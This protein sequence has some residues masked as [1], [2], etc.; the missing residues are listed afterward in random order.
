MK[1]NELLKGSFLLFCCSLVSANAALAQ[2]AKPAAIDVVEKEEAIVAQQD[3]VSSDTDDDLRKLDTVV[4]TGSRRRGSARGDFAPTFE[5]SED[6]IT[7]FAAGDLGE[8]VESLTPLLGGASGSSQE[9]PL[10]LLNGKRISGFREIRS[11]PPEAL[12]RVDVLPPE[13][14]LEYGVQTNQS[15]INFVLKTSFQKSTGEL[16]S[17]APTDGGQLQ[18]EGTFNWLRTDGDVRLSVDASYTKQTDLLESD[19]DIEAS[20]TLLGDSVGNVTGIPNGAEID[21]ALSA[22]FGEIVTLAGGA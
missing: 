17:R 20:R 21:P 12:I 7:S 9:R 3:I 22:I 5:L 11:Y 2:N 16:G 6:E 18:G 1:S 13:T 4:V 10:I 15:V 8:L 14:G 19:R